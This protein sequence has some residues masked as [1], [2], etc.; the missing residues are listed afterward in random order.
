MKNPIA[1]I[2]DT[3]NPLEDPDRALGYAAVYNYTKKALNAWHITSDAKRTMAAVKDGMPLHAMGH[4]H[5]EHGPGL[6]MSA[7]PQLWMGRA[8]EKWRF[9]ETLTDDERQVLTDALATIVLRQ[10]QDGYIT[11]NEY[12]MANRDLGHFV[13]IGGPGFVLQLAG[14]PFNISFWKKGFLEPLGIKPGREPEVIEFTLKGIW[15]VL[16][17]IPN[18]NEIE[19]LVIDEYDGALLRGGLVTVAQMV[20]WRSE[21]IVGM[22][23]TK[24]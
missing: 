9:L 11:E 13:E 23:R 15:A 19:G 2:F 16:D 8:H 14:Q 12:K 1:A 7:V 20:V 3:D 24:L 17:N 4:A 6:Y 10:R 18:P 22:K 21:A 5:Q